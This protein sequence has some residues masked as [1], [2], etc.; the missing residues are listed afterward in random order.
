MRKA[1]FS[2]WKLTALCLVLAIALAQGVSVSSA[3]NSL[4]PIAAFDEPNLSSEART[5]DAFN[6][7]LSNYNKRGVELSKKSTVLNE[8]FNALERTGNDLKRRVSQ[9]KDATQSIIS[10]LKAAGRWDGLNEELLAKL[11]AKD[12]AFVQKHGGL[13]RIL[14]DAVNQLDSQAADEIVAP[15]NNLRPKVAAQNKEFQFNEPQA[16]SWRMV[17]ANYSAPVAV[18]PADRR[19]ARCVGA[20]LRWAT[21][22]IARGPGTHTSSLSSNMHCQCDG[23]PDCMPGQIMVW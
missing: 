17:A 3:T 23:G 14:E 6:D 12:R 16:E 13:R 5:I 18:S 21:S 10:K 9:L 22:I 19:S 4:S 2:Y 8:E 1:R 11:D 20:T 15:L 7:D